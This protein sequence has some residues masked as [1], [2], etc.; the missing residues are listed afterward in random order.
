MN[1]RDF[2]FPS[3]DAP[4]LWERL[5]VCRQPLLIYGM[6][7][8]ADKLIRKLNREGLIYADTF[9]SDG[10]V[11]GQTFHDR[12]VLSLTEAEKVY[13]SFTALLS[14]GSRL[15]PVLDDLTALARR[16]SLLVPDLPVAGETFFDH[17]FYCAHREDL[18]RVCGLLSDE[19]SARLFA[20]LVQCRYTGDFASLM[21]AVREPGPCALP[22]DNFRF[23]VDVGAYRGDTAAALLAVAPAVERIV[24]IEPDRKNYRKLEQYAGAER[25]VQPVFGAAGSHAGVAPFFVSGNRNA[26]LG[27]SGSYGCVRENVPVVTVDDLCAGMHVDYIKYDVEGAEREVL[28]GSA[29]TIRRDRPCLSLALYHRPEDLFVLPE[30]LLSFGVP[31][32]LFLYRRRCVPA[33]E[34]DLYAIPEQRETESK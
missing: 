4:D 28:L 18:L 24:A 26:T 7:N 31:Y 29:Q 33:W 19:D 25:R 15:G 11:R 22:Y 8:G 1:R 16:R 10:F 5:R 3:A 6:G 17:S 27:E 23:C 14:F 9:A 34:T 21:Q 30:L 2:D 12:R 32:R 20:Q 13:G